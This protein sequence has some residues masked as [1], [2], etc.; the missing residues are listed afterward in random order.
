MTRWSPAR[1]L[2]ALV[3]LAPLALA[4]CDSSDGAAGGPTV[5]VLSPADGAQVAAPFTVKVQASVP[6]GPSGSGAHHVH[7]YFDDNDADYTI[8]ESDTGQIAKAPPGEHTLHVSLRNANH[9]P[10]GAEASIRVVVGGAPGG[11]GT[12]APGTSAPGDGPYGY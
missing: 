7:V 12:S 4:A 11:T 3:L 5:S 8:V 10:A 9:S 1:L 6:L 2:P